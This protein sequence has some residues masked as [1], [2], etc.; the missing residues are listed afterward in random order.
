M[1]AINPI[2]P[3]EF[4]NFQGHNQLIVPF[5]SSKSCS[6]QKKFSVNMS[7]FLRG[8]SCCTALLKMVDDW[9][10]ALDSKKIT[11]SIAIDLSQAFDSICHNL[12][13]AKLQAYGLND[14]AIAFLQ[15]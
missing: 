5:C 11:R 6:P 7:G 3:S 13:L 2:D 4:I 14:D 1:N 10:L 15:S 12:L 8:H 9:R